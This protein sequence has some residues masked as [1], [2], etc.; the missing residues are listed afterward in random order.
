MTPIAQAEIKL[1]AEMSAQSAPVCYC[2]TNEPPFPFHLFIVI[3]QVMQLMLTI[4]VSGFMNQ[5]YSDWTVSGTGSKK[6]EQ[7][8]ISIF[9]I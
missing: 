4:K 6:G 1:I 9:I 8:N 5:T 7:F 3:L 2:L